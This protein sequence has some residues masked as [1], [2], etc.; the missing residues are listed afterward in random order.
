MGR[1][2]LFLCVAAALAI[3]AFAACSTAS[4][5]RRSTPAAVSASNGGAT[6]ERVVDGDTIIVHVG[7]RRE[8]VRL[9]GIDTPESVKPN[10]PVQCFAIEAS[11]RTKSLLHPG[12]AVRL[13]GDVDQR[14]Q[15]KRLLAYVYRTDDNLFVNLAVVRDGYAVPYTF[16]P[17]VAH[18]SEFVAAA[19][20]ARDAGRGLWSAC[21]PDQRPSHADVATVRSDVGAR[22]AAGLSP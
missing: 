9:I 1:R 16:P 4:G 18:T 14:D 8:R 10:T 7:G 15:Y 12:T 6:V 3:V 2:G 20:Q 5:A 19:A 22:R 13:V 11:N 21:A 17:N